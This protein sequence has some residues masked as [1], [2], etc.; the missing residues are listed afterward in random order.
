M[1]HRP[2]AV[3]AR[4]QSICQICES[5][6]TRPRRVAG[7]LIA[8]RSASQ[9]RHEARPECRPATSPFVAPQTRASSSAVS[10]ATRRAPAAKS[11]SASSAP[12]ESQHAATAPSLHPSS[13]ADIMGYLRASVAKVSA[14][15]GVPSEQSVSAA[16][17]VCDMLA[18][19]FT[20]EA[21][22]PQIAHA[23][24]ELDST[25]STLLSLDGAAKT[26]TATAIATATGTARATPASTPTPTPTPTLTRTPPAAV[27]SSPLP[28]G[29]EY[30]AKV[31]QLVNKISETA[32][33]IIAHPPVFITPG[34]LRQYVRIQAK[35]GKPETLPRVFQLY[36]SK[37]LPREGSGPL[38][39][40]GRNPDRAANA[41]ESEI[42]EM[43]LDTAIEA[44]N[45]DAAVGIVENSYATAAFVRSKLLRYG[46]LPFGTFAVTP[47]AAYVLASNFSG[48]QQSMDSGMATTVAFTGILA[49]VG[50]TASIGMV[51]LTTANDQ[52]KRVTWAPGMPLRKR[53]IREDER[54]ALDKIA[55]AWGFQETGRQGE[56]A[57]ADWNALREYIGQKG[58]ILDRPELMDGMD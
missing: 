33:L 50:F 51:A 13:V 26:E 49:Y 9:R 35:L 15:R 25:A 3:V 54:A 45:L 37:P 31:R 18:N 23:I 52:M 32:Y 28:E 36:A 53:W 38:T 46:L 14:S 58:M 21:V 22:Q 1:I 17:E 6:S 11:T 8:T 16:L 4:P 29:I 27:P 19:W 57:G 47:F 56:E 30:S 55:C 43:A 7:P 44:K 10:P 20:D 34:L 40:T 5:I 12:I 2:R 41:I 42:V 24:T 39:Y 48:L